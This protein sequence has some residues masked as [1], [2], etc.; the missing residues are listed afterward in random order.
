MRLVNHSWSDV[1]YAQAATVDENHGDAAAE[2]EFLE[3]IIMGGN[4]ALQD[5]NSLGDSAWR[6]VLVHKKS[7]TSWVSTV[8]CIPF[9]SI[10]IWS[11]S[12][13]SGYPL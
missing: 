11:V 10:C 7:E 5:R 2:R 9:A 8:V 6:K 12:A 3:S 1:R 4:V 13:A